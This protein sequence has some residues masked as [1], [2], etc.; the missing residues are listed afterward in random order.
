[1]AVASQA[2]RVALL[3]ITRRVLKSKEVTNTVSF[4]VERTLPLFERDDNDIPFVSGG[5]LLGMAL[6]PMQGSLKAGRHS[7]PKKYRLM[8]HYIDHSVISYQI[9]RDYETQKLHVDTL[10]AKFSVWGRNLQPGID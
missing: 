3:T 9:F 10:W 8:L 2:G 6:G 4:R 5:G 1:M 7:G